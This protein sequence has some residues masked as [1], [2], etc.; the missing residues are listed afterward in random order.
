[1]TKIFIT[2][3]SGYVGGDAL[4]ALTNKFP[5]FEFV[6]L[7]RSPANAEEV[8][9]QY[10]AVKVVLGSLEDTDV[11]E[12]ES[13]AADIV[14]HCGDA[15]DNVPGAHAIAAGLA[16]THTKENPGYWLHT[17]GTGV[18]IFADL[19]K[20]VFGEAGDKI[21]D[22]WDGVE[23]LVNLPAH[24]FHR[25]VDE[26]VLAT[27]EKTGGAVR[28]ALVCP[29]TIYGRGRGPLSQRGRQVYSLAQ[30]TLLLNKAP[31]IG[32]GKA[33]WN[34]IHLYDLSDLWILLVEAALAGRSDEGLWGSKAYYLTE[35]GEHAWGTLAHQLAQAAVKLGYL[36]QPTA[37][38]ISIEEAKSFAGNEALTWG[39][40]SRGRALRARKLL[41][42]TPSR[43]SLVEELPTVLQ[44]EQARAHK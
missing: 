4:Y 29:P 26:I 32:A 34:N 36:D 27:Q 35:N 23:E 19:D 33:I 40:N 44:S 38:E 17:G 39:L 22:D 42:W 14:V 10:P 3:V 43:H 18:L 13:A 21:Y 9:K 8:R 16:R 28:T 37:E 30:M 41:G 25:N 15:S 1:M 6:V 2:G 20:G 11:V 31:I 24:A 12:R 5:S 7:I